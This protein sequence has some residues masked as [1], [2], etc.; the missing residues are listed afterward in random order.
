MRVNVFWVPGPW[1][2]K[3]GIVPRPRGGDWLEDEAK[4]W[5]QAGI[6]VVVSLLEPE[7]EAQLLPEATKRSSE[8]T[9]AAPRFPERP[10][11]LTS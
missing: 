6:D 5:H 1:P 8:A 7:E 11:L 10:S 9:V 2:G 3:L 4:A